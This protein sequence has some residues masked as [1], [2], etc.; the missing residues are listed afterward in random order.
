MQELGKTNLENRFKIRPAGVLDYLLVDEE[1]PGGEQTH[2]SKKLIG[3]LK[4]AKAI[5][6]CSFLEA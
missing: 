4:I 3:D 6:S 5:L 1:E 2:V